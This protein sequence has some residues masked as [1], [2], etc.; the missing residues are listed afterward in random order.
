MNPRHAA[1]LALVGWYLMVPPQPL[2]NKPSHLGPSALNPNGQDLPYTIGLPDRD[3][4]ISQ[5]HSVGS[6]DSAA[7]CKAALNGSE[8]RYSH[9]EAMMRSL[10]DAQCIASDDPRLK[11][12]SRP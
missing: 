8:K 4:P 3:A 2:L 10:F 12:N 5:W 11:E 6:F 9:D 7:E 1:A